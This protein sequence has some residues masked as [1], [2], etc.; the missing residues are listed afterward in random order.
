MVSRPIFVLI[1]ILLL[2]L[3]LYAEAPKRVL[4][5][6]SYNSRFPTFFQQI[7]GVK[8]V[9][10]T[11][12]AELDIEFLDR[13]RF[14]DAKSQELFY[15]TLSHKLA[16]CAPYDAVLAADDDAFNFV[17][18]YQDELF[19]DIPIAFFGVNNIEKALEQNSNPNVCG[20]IEAVSMQ[21]TLEL[22]I[23]LFPHTGSVYCISDST[24][25]GLSDLNLYRQ[26]A[27]Q[28]PE[29]NFRELNFSELSLDGFKNEL[30]AIPANAPVLLLSAYF[31]RQHQTFDFDAMLETIREHTNAPIFHLWEHGMGKGI[32]GGKLISQYEQGKTAADMVNRLLTHRSECSKKIVD[33]SPN[34]FQFDYQQLLKYNIGLSQ[35]PP[36]SVIIN[37]PVTF[38]QR[39]KRIIFITGVIF[40]TLVLLIIA[41]F[42][43]ILKRKKI[44]YELVT[45]N[46]NFAQLNR[47]LR[48]AKDKAEESNQLK[49]EF[50]NNMS[51]EI[52][53]PL[54]GI[55]GFSELLNNENLAVEKRKS[56]TNIVVRSGYQLLS[57]IDDILEISRLETR[58]V[59]LNV[60]TF[61]LNTLFKEL[62]ALFLSRMQEKGLSFTVEI[63]LEDEQSY[64]TTDKAKLNR[65]LINL[66]E[67]ALKFTLK[68]S[69]TLGYWIGDKH[70]TIYVKDTGV[71]ISASNRE[72]IFDRFSQEEKNLSQQYGGLGLGLAISKENAR[73][74]GGDISVESEKN[75]G[76]TFYVTIP[77]TV[78]QQTQVPRQESK[79]QN[80]NRKTQA[81]ILIAEDEQVNYLYIETLLQNASNYSF[82]LLHAENGQQA[83]E[84]CLEHA[85]VDLVL[86]DIKMPKLNGIEATKEIKAQRPNLPI[87]AVTA[88][89]SHA[90]QRLIKKCGCDAFVSKPIDKSELFKY[91]DHFLLDK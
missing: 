46:S 45:Q 13:K 30:G 17:L 52:R 19:S 1:S 86:M 41:L 29:T 88:Y 33:Q 82:K 78:P 76:S 73:L 57:I 40:A 68:G 5:I 23:Y 34:I 54:N 49:T 12:H 71:G 61:C 84:T 8:S 7:E 89:S 66:I 90:D 64:I 75:Q 62:R 50:L 42:I 87:I 39:N 83:V 16:H 28:Y 72:R 74:L 59:T 35:L 15:Q 81:T 44:E 32:F 9:L 21:E 37:R 69:V 26:L 24:S 85:E 36:G 4:L 70:I 18:H 55:I 53:T 31:D 48:I 27:A 47:E 20:V 79:L 56:Y 67:N 14:I 43:N 51:H 22:M 60:D 65:I 3:E 38:W 58:Q 25:S 10:D 80:R 91:I 77:A 11:T 2:A 63:S 6:S